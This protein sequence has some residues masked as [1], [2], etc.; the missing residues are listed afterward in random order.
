MKI[1]I[2]GKEQMLDKAVS[3]YEL[4]DILKIE[5]TQGMAIAVNESVVRKDDWQSYMLKE[6]DNVLLIKATRGG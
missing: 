4:L 3:I 5:E 2:N 1:Q 6:D